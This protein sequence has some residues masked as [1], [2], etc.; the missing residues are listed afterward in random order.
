LE[1]YEMKW[2]EAQDELAYLERDAYV[3]A[4]KPM[5]KHLGEANDSGRRKS[6]KE[7]QADGQLPSPLLT[8]EEQRN[9]LETQLSAS[10]TKVRLQLASM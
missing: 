4:I 3:S 2:K 9:Q 6:E 8:E 1:F 5:P 10:Q 7:E